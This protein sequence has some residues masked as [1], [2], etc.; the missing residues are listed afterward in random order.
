MDEPADEPEP[1]EEP[2]DEPIVDT[3]PAFDDFDEVEGM[4]VQVVTATDCP[5]YEPGDE[6][7]AWATAQL[8]G[9]TLELTIPWYPVLSGELVG[10]ELD[11]VFGYQP[12]MWWSGDFVSCEVNGGAEMT[13]Q[14][15][16][17][18]LSEVLTHPDGSSC[19]TTA[20]FEL[21]LPL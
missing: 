9:G 20:A 3:E 1:I 13:L 12:L 11:D 14:T 17:G 15:I 6:K 21:A 19:T 5:Y 2:V 10:S 7:T 8:S 4:W 16:S 18:T